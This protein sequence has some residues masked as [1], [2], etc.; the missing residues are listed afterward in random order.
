VWQVEHNP[1]AIRSVLTNFTGLPHRLELVREYKSIRY[2]DDSFGTTPETAI[3]AIE[4]FKDPKV[5]ILGGSDKGATY[6]DLAKTV[7]NN[8]VRS[9]VAI[10][11]TGPAITEALHKAGFT[12]I[13]E[14]GKTMPEIVAIAQQQA[15]PGDV[16]LLSTAC[17]SFDLFKNYKDRGEQFR[18]A[19]QALA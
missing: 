1:D 6:Q 18:T 19:V 17:A 13:V 11:A 9:V 3:V 10:G 15:Q 7:R 14:G 5:V 8:N 12:Q 16:V 2:Y 4:A